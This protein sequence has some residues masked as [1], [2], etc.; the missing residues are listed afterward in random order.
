MCQITYSRFTTPRS[1]PRGERRGVRRPSQATSFTGCGGQ[2][3]QAAQRKP[4]GLDVGRVSCSASA[5]APMRDPGS[6]AVGLYTIPAS[7]RRSWA[8]SC[9][10]F[11]GAA[12]MA[13]RTG[14]RRWGC[15]DFPDERCG[16]CPAIPFGGR[17]ILA[18]VESLD[19]V[20]V[21]FGAF[22]PGNVPALPDSTA[23]ESWSRTG[24]CTLVSPHFCR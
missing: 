10:R 22:F 13:E 11:P 6:H 24:C 9:P 3:P 14:R 8:S 16:R 12:E 18:I 21:G 2:R 15:R 4:S 23:R 7:S 19:S 17:G 20:N 1:S 5:R